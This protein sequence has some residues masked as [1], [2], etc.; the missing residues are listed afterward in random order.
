MP[1][2]DLKKRLPIRLPPGVSPKIGKADRP[3]AVMKIEQ[4]KTYLGTGQVKPDTRI[5]TDKFFHFS[6]KGASLFLSPGYAGGG[7]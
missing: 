6:R 1:Y 2:A 3:E 7:L 4:L 5:Y